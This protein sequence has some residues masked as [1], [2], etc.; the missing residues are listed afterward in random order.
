M[1]AWYRNIQTI[2]EEIDSCIR[3][4]ADDSLTLTALAQHLGYSEYTVSRRFREISGMT[5]KH[6]VHH[7]KLAFALKEVRDTDQSLL[8]IALRY[9]YSSHEAF[10]RTFKEAFG[11]S[12]SE[13]RAHPF[14]TAL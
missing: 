3:S 7:R 8:T 13:Y 4:E 5:L 1:E 10:S 12:P 9:G 2:V 11:V 6:Y 14:P